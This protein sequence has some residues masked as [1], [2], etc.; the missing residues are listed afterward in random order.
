MVGARPRSAWAKLMMRLARYTSA[1]PSAHQ[2]GEAT[3]HQAAH[4]DARGSEG[5]LLHDD[6]GDRGPNERT[7]PANRS[8]RASLIVSRG[9]SAWPP[10]TAPS[11]AVVLPTVIVPRLVL[12]VPLTTAP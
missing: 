11:R 9:S 2:C 6:D 8:R 7:T 10:V 3:H 1:M 12:V 5:E 4:D